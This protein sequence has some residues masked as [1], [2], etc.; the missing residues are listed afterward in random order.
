M[1]RI[2]A[3]RMTSQL[4]YRLYPFYRLYPLNQPGPFLTFSTGNG[5]KEE[6]IKGT[7]GIKGIKEI[8]GIK[9]IKG[10][11][12]SLLLG[13]CGLLFGDMVAIYRKGNPSA[14]DSH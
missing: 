12:V 9:G 7:K 14:T 2:I 13:Q 3:F 4:P 1:K 11:H 6:G 5:G 10:I 8:K